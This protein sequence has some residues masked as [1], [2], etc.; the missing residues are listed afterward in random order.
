MECNFV[1]THF[2]LIDRGWGDTFFF[3]FSSGSTIA[4]EDCNH[5]QNDDDDDDDND[6]NDDDNDDDDNDDDDNDDDDDDNYDNN[7]NDDDDD[8]DDDS[9][10]FDSIP[11][12]VSMYSIEVYSL[13]RFM[14]L[15]RL[16]YLFIVIALTCKR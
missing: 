13:F 10:D 11:I 8:D 9:S 12:S 3:K 16:F 14:L 2:N 4:C 7:N 6:D 1:L 5:Y 15:L